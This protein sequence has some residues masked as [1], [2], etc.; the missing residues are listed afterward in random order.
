[1]SLLK[2]KDI[3]SVSLLIGICS[4]LSLI[5][6]GMLKDVI[7]KIIL[8]FLLWPILFLIFS[9]FFVYGLAMYIQ[10]HNPHTLSGIWGI[11]RKFSRGKL[12][13]IN[14]ILIMIITGSVML[15]LIVELGKR[16]IQYISNLLQ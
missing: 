15:M 6:V 9:S 4:L 1:M 14:G 10:K 16:I 3:F 2:S 12:P 8:D 7:P 5:I 11:S 13:Q